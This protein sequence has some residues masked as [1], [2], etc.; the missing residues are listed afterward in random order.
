MCPEL[1]LRD[2]GQ[3]PGRVEVDRVTVDDW[4]VLQKI[5][6]NAVHPSGLEFVEVGQGGCGSFEVLGDEGGHHLD[7]EC[8]DVEVGGDRGASGG[9]CYGG[10]G[11]LRA[12]GLDLGEAGVDVEL[13]A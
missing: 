12:V 6:L 7:G 11:D 8:C 10:A 13:Y 1:R 2:G 9:S 4:L 5:K 3:R